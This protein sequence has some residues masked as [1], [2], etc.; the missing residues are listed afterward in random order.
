MDKAY[1]YKVYRGDNF[2]GILKD[3]RSVFRYSQDVN[4]AGSS[5]SIDV[6][7]NADTSGLPVEEILDEDGDPI[8]DETGEALLEESAPVVF[9][10]SSDDIQLRNGNR[11]EVYEYSDYYPNGKRMFVGIINRL[12]ANFG[13]E[14][15]EEIITALVYSRGSELDNYIIQDGIS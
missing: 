6:A 3:V 14:S 10:N 7:I 9:G 2:L 12:E 13:G 8:L 4:S 15:N 5:T 11:V 1:T